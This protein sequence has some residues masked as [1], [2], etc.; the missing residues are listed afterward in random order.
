MTLL[1]T[2][3]GN[4]HFAC[5]LWRKI[6]HFMTLR[7]ADRILCN[8]GILTV[9]LQA[10]A[11]RTTQQPRRCK[12]PAS[13]SDIT[14]HCIS[15]GA[16]KN[17]RCWNGQ[18][19]TLSSAAASARSLRPRLTLPIRRKARWTN[20]SMHEQK[21]SSGSFGMTTLNGEN[22]HDVIPCM[23]KTGKDEVIVRASA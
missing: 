3:S 12:S 8:P 14:G 6:R 22:R 4:L 23:H 1:L 2:R 17:K 7:P 20:E 18:T 5:H 15:G 16:R 10:N 11:H 19:R 21:K 9:Q 13:D